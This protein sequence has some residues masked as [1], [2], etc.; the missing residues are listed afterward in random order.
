M[1]D[2]PWL[3]PAARGGQEDAEDV[4]PGVSAP[5]AERAG[6]APAGA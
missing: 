1:L 6:S 5:T 4:L 3:V 2:V